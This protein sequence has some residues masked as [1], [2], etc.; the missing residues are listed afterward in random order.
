MIDPNHTV[1]RTIVHIGVL[2]SELCEAKTETAPFVYLEIIS[3][4]P[5]RF[6]HQYFSGLL[7]YFRV[8]QLCAG[9][10]S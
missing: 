10:I 8:M 6:V 3:A 9:Y 1:H 7:K 4:R 2:V 5:E